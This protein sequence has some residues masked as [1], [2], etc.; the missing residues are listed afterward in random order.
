MSKPLVIIVKNRMVQYVYSPKPCPTEIEIIDLDFN[1]SNE[2]A[3]YDALE[4]LNEV[5][6]NLYKLY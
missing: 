3:E 6:Q 4:R 2:D 5:R 1:G